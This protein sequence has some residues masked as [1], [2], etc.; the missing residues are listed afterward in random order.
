MILSD[1]CKK[2]SYADDCYDWKKAEE[3]IGQILYDY[4]IDLA[5]KD[6]LKSEEYDDD[7]DDYLDAD[8]VGRGFSKIRNY[9]LGFKAAHDHRYNVENTYYYETMMS[10]FSQLVESISLIYYRSDV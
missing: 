4:F 2:Y 7:F 10:E 5:E 1:A 6:K 3:K 9:V 8:I